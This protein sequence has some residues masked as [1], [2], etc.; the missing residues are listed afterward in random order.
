MV[1]SV[2]WMRSWPVTTCG[3]DIASVTEKP[4]SR[5]D[6][7]LGLRDG[8]GEHRLARQQLC[9]HGR[10]LR[11]LAGEHPHRTPVVAT[12]RGARTGCRPR[13]PSRSASTSSARSSAMTA[14]RTGAV[15]TP[16]RQGVGEVG[17]RDIVMCEHPVGQPAGSAAQ[18]VRRGRRQREQQR[19]R[20]HRIARNDLAAQRV[21]GGRCLL[22]HAVHVGPGKPVRRHRRAPG[23][24]TVGGPR[25]CSCGTK[26]LVSMP[27]SSSGSRVKCR[28]RGTTSCC[29]ARTAF[30]SPS[31]P[32]ADWVWPKFVF[33]DVS[34]QGPSMP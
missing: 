32:A 3:A 27:A 25:E 11:T 7:R 23:V 17:Q 34:A 12:E 1:N 20:G 5:K 9:A 16:T 31:T 29:S 24:V 13:R 2:G 15:R 22:Q 6:H 14:V 26:S 33:D 4:H 30:I 10:P 8:R 21:Q 19:R 28:F 18:F